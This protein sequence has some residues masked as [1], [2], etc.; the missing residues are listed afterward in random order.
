MTLRGFIDLHIHGI[1]KF[2]TQTDDP[3]YILNIAEMHPAVKNGILAGSGITLRDACQV[4]REVG[5]PEAEIINAAI[6][7]PGRYLAAH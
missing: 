6:H 3:H 5:V 4:L 7:N 1:D 2:D